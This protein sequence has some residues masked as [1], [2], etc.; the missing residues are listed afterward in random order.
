VKRIYERSRGSGATKTSFDASETFLI[1]KLGKRHATELIIL[2][3][4][5][6]L[7]L[8]VRRVHRQLFNQLEK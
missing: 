8:I 7:N 3:G 1:G 5:I 4:A 2:L 6:T